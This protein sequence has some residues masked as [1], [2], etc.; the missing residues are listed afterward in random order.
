MQALREKNCNIRSHHTGFLVSCKCG[1]GSVGSVQQP[2]IP[3]NIWRH[4][5]KYSVIKRRRCASRPA[6]FWSGTGGKKCGT[7]YLVSHTGN[8]Y[9]RPVH[10]W[11][12]YTSRLVRLVRQQIWTNKWSECS[13]S[14]GL[15][16]TEFGLDHFNKNDTI[17]VPHGPVPTLTFL[18][19][20]YAATLLEWLVQYSIVISAQV[21]WRSLPGWRVCMD[22]FTRNNSGACAASVRKLRNHLCACAT[23]LYKQKNGT[24]FTSKLVCKHASC[25]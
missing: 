12:W 17:I 19:L 24:E 7:L 4:I 11:C 10:F 23:C 2:F 18:M 15:G 9:A 1:Y 6:T 13:I 16:F 22:R 25:I 21:M 20:R 8:A 14:K 3:E 5:V